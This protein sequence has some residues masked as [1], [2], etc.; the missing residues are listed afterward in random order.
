V[1]IF[2]TLTRRT[3]TEGP[4]ASREL[5]EPLR[6]LVPARF[7]AVGEALASG[8]GS[9]EACTVVGRAL[10]LDGAALDEVL[11]GLRVTSRAVLG[12]DPSFD[13][14]QALGTAWSEATLGYLHQL[15]C[16]D[17]LTGL[18]S[19][20]HVRSRLSELYR[21]ELREL[22]RVQERRALVVAD[23]PED[24]G[25]SAQHARLSR[26]LRI[27]RLGESARTVWNGTETIGR[28]GQNR[29]VVLVERDQTL[30]RRV[31]LFR[32]LL[33]SLELAGHTPRVWIEGLPPTDAGAAHLLD[34]LARP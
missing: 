33:G 12:R 32:T 16:E 20:A 23:L 17:P 11:V 21:G 7:E 2:A 25:G 8:S 24:R 30:G 18:A 1:G 28:L 14:I 31:A 3:L 13:D 5:P 29:I 10:A 26:T 27:A 15:S 4:E 6:T 19:L 22:G 34:E 9:V